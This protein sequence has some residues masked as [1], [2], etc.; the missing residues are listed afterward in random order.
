MTSQFFENKK[1]HPLFPKKWEGGHADPKWNTKSG[2]SLVFFFGGFHSILDNKLKA[3]CQGDAAKD[4][5][6]RTDEELD[7]S[8]KRPRCWRQFYQKTYADNNGQQA[9]YE[10]WDPG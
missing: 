7:S 4:H 8:V 9:K 3:V 2:S 5:C 10:Q 1:S 6:E